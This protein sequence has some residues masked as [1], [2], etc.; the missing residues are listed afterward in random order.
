MLII[1]AGSLFH[2]NRSHLAAAGGSFR[3]AS[4]SSPTT[5]FSHRSGNSSRAYPGYSYILAGQSTSRKGKQPASK[6]M[7]G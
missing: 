2:R 7:S 6:T 1:S 5:S 3:G 4:G